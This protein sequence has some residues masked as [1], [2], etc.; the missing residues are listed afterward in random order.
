MRWRF[1]SRIAAVIKFLAD[2]SFTLFLTHY[3]VLLFLV[4]SEVADGWAAFIIGVMAS[5]VVAILIAL[6]TEM[7]YKVLAGFMLKH[8]HRLRRAMA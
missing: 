7:R 1:N 3:T 4:Y 8:W 5:N 6:P 2:Y